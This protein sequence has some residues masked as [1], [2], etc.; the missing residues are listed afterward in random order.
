MY[1]LMYHNVSTN[2]H[3]PYITPQLAIVGVFSYTHNQQLYSNFT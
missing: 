2:V 1:P 3:Y